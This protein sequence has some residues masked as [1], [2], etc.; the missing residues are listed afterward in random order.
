MPRPLN[1]QFFVRP[2]LTDLPFEEVVDEL[3]DFDDRFRIILRRHLSV[4]AWWSLLSALVGLPAIFLSTGPWPYFWMMTCSWAAINFAIVVGI[5]YHTAYQRFARGNTFQRFRV[6][7]HMEKMLLFNVGLDI[8]Y[9][10]AGL[11]LHTLGRLPDVAYPELWTGFGW[12]VLL[13]GV[14]LFGQD[15]FFHWLHR[16]NFRLARHY[17]EQCLLAPESTVDSY[18][19]VDI[20]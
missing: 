13:Q 7:W 5:L 6:Q 14:Y 9:V 10:C 12:A 3:R 8:A 1:W 17:L 16:K 11:Y 18:S 19:E 20:N 2:L 15:N 4:L